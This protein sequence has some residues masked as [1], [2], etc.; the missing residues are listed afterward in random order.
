MSIIILYTTISYVIQFVS[1][2]HP[3]DKS[4]FPVY[5]CF[6]G[7]S[8]TEISPRFKTDL[9]KKKNRAEPNW[10][11]LRTE[12]ISQNRANFENEQNS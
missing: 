8:K 6:Q 5:T 12:Q 9:D 2:R 10:A 4:H 11:F 3:P 1:D 7:M